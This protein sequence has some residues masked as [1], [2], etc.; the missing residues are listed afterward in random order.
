[1]RIAI[2]SDVHGNLSAFQ[3]VAA[4]LEKRPAFDEIIFAGDLC[5]FGPQPQECLA[6]LR[7]M[8]IPAITGNTDE[9]IRH[10]PPLSETMPDEQRK[11]RQHL[12]DLCRWTEAQLNPESLAWLD[13]LRASFQIRLTPTSDPD[14]DLLVVHANPHDLL[15]VIFPSI[16]RQKALYGKV[17]QSDNELAPLLEGLTAQ[18]MAFGHLHI[19]GARLWRGKKLFNISSA[20]LPGDGDGRAKYAILT[21]DGEAGWTAEHIYLEVDAAAEIDAF[22][23]QRPPGWQQ[24]VE[25]LETLGYMPQVV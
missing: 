19:P 9:W 15:G 20:S 3:A 7:D 25:Q 21:W 22:R 14:D 10:P 16:E 17:R 11:A 4:D 23:R 6:L 2:F 24:R 5:L 12:Q 18:T 8:S 1:M 13:D